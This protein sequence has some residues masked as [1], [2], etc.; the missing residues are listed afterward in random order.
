M[1]RHRDQNGVAP[2]KPA[3]EKDHQTSTHK[4]RSSPTGPGNGPERG[5]LLSPG[6][7]D[8]PAGQVRRFA[9]LEIVSAVAGGGAGRIRQPADGAIH[10]ARISP[11]ST[12]C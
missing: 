4:K 10:H 2:D 3:R 1:A 8:P 6:K 7:A 5:D 12:F 9:R 11:E